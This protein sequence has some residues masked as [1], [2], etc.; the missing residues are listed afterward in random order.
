MSSPF[1]AYSRCYDLL[2]RDKDYAAE[3]AY[4]SGLMRERAP[5]GRRVL[6]LGCGTG[7]HAE[8]LARLGY[9]VQGIDLSEGMLERAQARRAVLPA[10]IAQRLTFSLGDA[11]SLRLAA[12]FDVV[13]AMFHVMSYQTTNADLQAAYATAGAHLAAGG[14]FLYDY[15]YGPA[16]L[17]QLPSVRVRR[18][19]DELT[20]VTRIAEPVMHWQRN[21]CDV[22]LTLF[23]ETLASGSVLQFPE[24]HPMRYLFPPELALIEG[25]QWHEAQ[26]HAWMSAQAPDADSWY[27]LRVLSK[28]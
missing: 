16:V 1:E 25:T 10:Q 28:A 2:Y 7:G 23:V 14:V 9:T 27:A 5:Q 4:V 6:E 15:W 8:Q 26:D 20:R 18:L 21:V 3:T 11:R 13:M 19:H 12:S 17:R 24:T 22:N